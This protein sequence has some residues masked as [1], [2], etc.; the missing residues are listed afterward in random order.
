MKK[1]FYDI[2]NLKQ[3]ATFAE[4]KKSYRKL[5]VKYHPDRNKGSK[6]CEDILKEIIEAYE[7][8][9]DPHKRSEYDK[10]LKVDVFTSQDTPDYYTTKN[11]TI[12]L[13]ESYFGCDK[14][15]NVI[16]RGG[17]IKQ[18]KVTIPRG[19]SDDT[20]LTVPGSGRFLDFFLKITIAY[21]SFFS[22]QGYNLTCNVTIPY[23]YTLMGGTTNIPWFD[24]MRKLHVKPGI[25]S[26]AQ[27][28]LPSMGMPIPNTGKYGD[29]IVT[30]NVKGL[31]DFSEALLESTTHSY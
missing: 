9:S 15:I 16:D 22:R 12:T 25:Y 20:L 14:H 29:L 28:T 4:I 17:D 10:R 23:V 7:C 3:Y 18:I 5:V 11:I 26:G 27:I 6:E 30:V 24:G 8:L 19:V 31:V 1:C 13:E 2:L 21:H